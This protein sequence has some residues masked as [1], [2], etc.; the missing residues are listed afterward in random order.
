M[1]EFCRKKSLKMIR[2]Q[3]MSLQSSVNTDWTRSVVV[4]PFLSPSST[5]SSLPDNCPDYQRVTISG[6]YCAGVST[7]NRSF[8]QSESQLKCFPALHIVCL[9][10]P[11][12]Y[13]H[14]HRMFKDMVYYQNGLHKT[15]LKINLFVMPLAHCY[16]FRSQWRIM[17]R[18]PEVCSKLCLFVRNTQS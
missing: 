7:M 18:Q 6:D 15:T 17:N 14:V 12:N 4:T 3:S 11:S 9:L 10:L 13:C 1:G 8:N 16:P 5:C 2:S